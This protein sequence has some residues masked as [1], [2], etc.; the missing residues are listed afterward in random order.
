MV[1]TLSKLQLIVDRNTLFA[2]SLVSDRTDKVRTACQQIVQPEIRDDDV[3][4]EQADMS[5]FFVGKKLGNTQV[6]QDDGNVVRVTVL[7]VGP[8]VVLG[9]RTLEKDGY[10]ALIVG[11]G[12]RKEKHTKKPVKGQF[13][14]GKQG[15]GLF[16][17]SKT[18]PKRTVRGAW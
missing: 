4:V 8:C 12:D 15:G 3:A 11:L 14:G 16:K 6:F 5:N 9:K 10:S 13:E 1:Q 7:R 18:G 17:E 2:V